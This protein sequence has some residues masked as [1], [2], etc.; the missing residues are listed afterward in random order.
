MKDIFIFNL[1]NSF[2]DITINIAYY[3]SIIIIITCNLTEI[4]NDRGFSLKW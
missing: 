4:I 2:R 3:F 1:Q